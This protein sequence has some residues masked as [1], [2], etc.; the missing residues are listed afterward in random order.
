M[1]ERISE[2][3]ADEDVSD[4]YVGNVHR[5]CS[6][7]L[8][9]NN[10]V[11][12]ETSIIDDDDA[13]SILARYLDE[14]EDKVKADYNLKHGY[15][16]IIQFS[17][18]MHQIAHHYPRDLRL[19]PDSLNSDDIAA[20]KFICKVEKRPFD[21]VAM[22]DI[23][24]HNDYYRD[25]IRSDAYAI[26]IQQMA[27]KLLHKMRFAH[28]F[29]AYM[30]QNKLM[31]F[32]DLLLFTYDAMNG[33]GQ[34]KRY[35]WIQVD[36]VQDLNPLQLAILD[37]ISTIDSAAP[38]DEQGEIL[39]L[40]DEQQAIFSFMGAKMDT[41][42]Q[43]KTRCQNHIH[44][45]NVN[46]RSP[47]YLL[48][49]FNQYA[50]D[51]L[52]IDKELLPTTPNH[53]KSTGRELKILYSNTLE[54]EYGDVA[55]FAA[56]LYREYPSDTT[57]VIVSA[58]KD[59]DEIS[60][61]LHDLGLPHFKI[62]GIDLF[63]T[64]EVK[65]LLAHLNVLCNENNFIAWARLLKGLN[66]FQTNAAAR[67]FMRKL[68]N[69]AILPSDFLLYD[70]STYVQDFVETYENEEIV[71][72]DTETTGLNIFEDDVLQIAAIKVKGGQKVAGSDFCVYLETEREI[73]PKLGDVVNPIIEE[74]K[75]HPILPNA[76]ALRQ[77]LAYAGD[78]VL[79]GHNVAFDVHIMDFNLRR[80]LKAGDYQ[81]KYFDTL[82]LLRLLEPNL[83]SYKLDDFRLRHLFGIQEDEAHLANVDVLDTLKVAVHCYQKAREILPSQ[84]EFLSR[85]NV[86]SR[87]EILRKNYLELYFHSK[88]L[89]YERDFVA[90]EP[91]LVSEMRRC[92]SAFGGEPTDDAGG[93]ARLSAGIS[94]A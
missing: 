33:E 57:A 10:V 71:L 39:Y 85:Q 36:E 73:P 20:M 80:Y 31:D 78:D 64:P 77:F 74:R 37:R 22:L 43:L 83:H 5:F 72:F 58:N 52:L 27:Q 66:V 89:L 32:E 3:I 42:S 24:E 50:T 45:L 67:D 15:E 55:Q 59:A 53:D 51:V 79:M 34:F 19:H 69:R 63:S 93:K 12:A 47:G 7:F 60:Q 62:S 61:S 13:V 54:E 6:K 82:K 2:N 9:E 28:A 35:P 1:Q 56:N 25:A 23:Y 18:L 17:H 14:E 88:N 65:L 48:Q 46:H 87:F 21:A 30:R 68:F 70:D 86:Q 81:P 75:H 26:G 40:G 4:L 76:E 84:M 16:Q 91:V 49:V 8:Y 94:V 44:H 90:S 11:E 29:T 41:L 92:L 38:S